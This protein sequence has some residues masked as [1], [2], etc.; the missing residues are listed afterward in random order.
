MLKIFYEYHNLASLQQDKK[1]VSIRYSSKI[2]HIKFS[3][4]FQVQ[5]KPK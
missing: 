4:S 5:S 2:P 3:Y 1:I